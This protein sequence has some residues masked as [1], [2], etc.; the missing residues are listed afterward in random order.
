MATIENLHGLIQKKVNIL[1]NV[2]K[3]YKK[4]DLPKNIELSIDDTLCKINAFLTSYELKSISKI[5]E[6]FRIGIQLNELSNDAQYTMLVKKKAQLYE[7]YIRLLSSENIGNVLDHYYRIVSIPLQQFNLDD[8]QHI[9]AMLDDYNCKH[10]EVGMQDDVYY[11][12]SKCIETMQRD[13]KSSE[14][15]C[16]KCGKTEQLKGTICE[17][18]QQQQYFQ[19]GLRAKTNCYVASKHAKIWLARILGE[20]AEEVPIEVIQAVRRCI[21]RDRLLLHAID[22]SIIRDYLK[23]TK[24][25]KYNNNVVQIKKIITNIEPPSMSDVERKNVLIIFDKVV[26]IFDKY[27][28]SIENSN[29]IQFHPAWLARI[30]DHVLSKPDDYARKREILS[31]IHKQSSTTIICNNEIWEKICSKIGDIPGIEKLRYKPTIFD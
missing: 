3:A 21:K 13:P 5:N 22:C 19:E 14:L 6:Y 17:E 28:V 26:E 11:I 23:E 25:T 20:E 9:E 8:S 7:Q 24:N 30:I 12:C 10:I 15:V 18:E 2:C 16:K 29:N 31:N 4:Y 27:I 1:I